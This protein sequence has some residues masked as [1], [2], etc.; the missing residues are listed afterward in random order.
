MRTK[1]E[2]IQ[3]T[4][5][6]CGKI[7]S[8]SDI[9]GCVSEQNKAYLHNMTFEIWYG[10]VFKIIDICLDCNSQIIGFM[11]TKGILKGQKQ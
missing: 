8:N 4:C 2:I 5:D 1:K 3:A 6:C 9:N 7:M 10:G 11:S